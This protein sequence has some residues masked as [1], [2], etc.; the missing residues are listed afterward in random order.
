MVPS[1]HYLLSRLCFSG[2]GGAHWGLGHWGD[3]IECIPV[4][5]SLMSAS[6]LLHPGRSGIALP[7]VVLLSELVLAMD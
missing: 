2:R 4:Q 7:L 3:E 1:I 5:G 6:L